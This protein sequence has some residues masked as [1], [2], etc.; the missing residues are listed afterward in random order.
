MKYLL[1]GQTTARLSFRLLSTADFDAWLPF[2]SD[3]DAVRFIG[4]PQEE[5]PEGRCRDWF[6]RIEARYREDRGGM[7]AL[8]ERSTGAFV[9]Q[10]G[11]LVQEVDGQ[12]ELE[13]SYS[14][15]PR[16]RGQGYAAEAARKCRDYAFE[17]GFADSLI[18]IIHVEN[19]PSARVARKNGLQPTKRTVF[20]GFPVDIFRI[21]RSVCLIMPQV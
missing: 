14:L 15:L 19:A 5:T 1:D 7:N 4:L 9:G 18:S 20:K 8:I 11:L 10:A 3:P 16:F 6:E 17:Q 12:A 13:I 21:E 2:C